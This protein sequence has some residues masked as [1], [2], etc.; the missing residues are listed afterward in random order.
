MAGVAK[1]STRS[2]SN[3]DSYDNTAYKKN[4]KKK[5][6]S[7]GDY[8]RSSVS[9]KASSIAA[10]ANLLARNN[11]AR[12]ES[13]REDKPNN[14]ENTTDSETTQNVDAENANTPIKNTNTEN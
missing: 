5:S 9:Y 4:N 7:G 14:T 11:E 8:K 2:Y 3:D 10:N 1:T 12:T 6:V 13:K